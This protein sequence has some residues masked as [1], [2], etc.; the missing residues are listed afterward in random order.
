[1]NNPGNLQ[2][3]TI[4]VSQLVPQSTTAAG[5]AVPATFIFNVTK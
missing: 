1:V 2:T 4:P 5:A 3:V